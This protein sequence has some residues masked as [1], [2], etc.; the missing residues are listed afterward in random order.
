MTALA[1]GAC[2][3]GTIEKQPDWIFIDAR[4]RPA[5]SYAA[6]AHGSSMLVRTASAPRRICMSTALPGNEAVRLPG[7]GAG[8]RTERFFK[9]HMAM[10]LSVAT[11]MRPFL[12]NMISLTASEGIPLERLSS[13][14][15][16]V[17]S[18]RA[19]PA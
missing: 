11:Q 3:S 16:P 9:S 7:L 14:R 15:Q 13:V 18:R 10:P 4:Q 2:G 5:M 19:I 17:L 1:A 6:M 12:S 8:R